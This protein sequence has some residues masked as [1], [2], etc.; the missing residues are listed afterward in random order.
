MSIFF[1]Y[2]LFNV[3]LF[4]DNSSWHVHRNLNRFQSYIKKKDNK[5]RMVKQILTSAHK[6]TFDNIILTSPIA[7]SSRI[8]TMDKT[9][10]IISKE[11]PSM[12]TSIDLQ[13]SR[14]SRRQICQVLSCHERSILNDTH[15]KVAE[16]P[17]SS[18][19]EKTS[20]VT[21]VSSQISDPPD[22]ICQKLS[23]RARI[24]SD[25]VKKKNAKEAILMTESFIPVD[26]KTEISE[27]NPTTSVDSSSIALADTTVVTETKLNTKVTKRVT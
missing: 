8:E 24:N 19:K 14:N 25:D 2:I 16:K 1:Q 15:E 6:D 17:S 3:F 23:S 20:T 13:A 5:M 21:L 12:T 4:W 11:E 26:S 22:Q 9:N 18:P 7:S 27:L 10:L